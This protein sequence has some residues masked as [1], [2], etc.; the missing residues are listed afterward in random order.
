[1]DG[2]GQNDPADFPALLELARVGPHSTWSA[3]GGSTGGIPCCAARCRGWPTASGAPSSADRV[4]D[5][6]CQLRVMR[7]E[8]LAAVQPMEL[9]QAFIPALAAAAGFRVGRAAGAPPPAAARPLEVRPRQAV[10]AARRR[11]AAPAPGPVAAPASMSAD[12][13]PPR[14]DGDL[15]RDHRSPARRGRTPGRRRPR[16][17]GSSTGWR[18]SSAALSSRATSPAPT[19]CPSAGT[20]GDRRRRAGVP[21]PR[22]RGRR[23]DAGAPSTRR[24]ARSAGRGSRTAPPPSPSTRHAHVL[25]SQA[26]RLQLDLGAVGKGYALDRMADVLAEWG[27]PSV[28]SQQRREHR[29]GPGQSPVGRWVAGRARRGRCPPGDRSQARGAQRLWAGREGP[30][31]GRS[32]GP[33]CRRPGP[34]G[35]GPW[36]RAPPWPTPCRPRSSSWPTP[37]WLDSARPIRA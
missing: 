18:A 25:T 7:R 34:C 37:R 29:A 36:R 5:A 23:G 2:D 16:R 12:R 15:V 13:L 4:H 1:M 27:V 14:G 30:P 31:P 33:A 20:D 26:L 19:A 32:R 22:G 8:V 9:L 6:G 21:P 35:P 17:S 10:V 24:T 28:R 11:D 3:A